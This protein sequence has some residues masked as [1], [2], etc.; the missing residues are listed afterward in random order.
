MKT[1]T[2]YTETDR[3]FYPTPKE[4]AK[5]MLSGIKWECIKNILEPSAGKG[6]LIEAIEE[7]VVDYFQN[8][9]V[10]WGYSNNDIKKEFSIDCIEIDPYLRAI[11]KGTIEKNYEN[12]KVVYDDFL[13]FITYKKYD[14]IVMNPP[15]R[16][17]YKHL[18]KALEM[19]KNGGSVICLLN[20]ETL[21]NPNNALQKELKAI[22]DKYD[23]DIEYIENGFSAAERKTDVEIA[24]IKVFI[25]EVERESDIY[26]GMKKAVN[27]EVMPNEDI[28]DLD[29]T[30][31]IKMIVTHY[32]IET[33]A[34]IKLINEYN[35][36]SPYIK[37]SFEKACYNYPMLELRMCDKSS[38]SINDYVE[39]VRL[40]YWREL[41]SNKKIMSK[42]TSALQEKYQEEVETLADYDFNEFNINNLIIE[43]NASLN[44]G[45]ADE[46]E[47]MYDRLT[48]GYTY[49]PECKNNRHYYNGWKTN[50]AHK[51]GKKVI[52]PTYG[53]YSSW[54]SKLN[55]RAAYEVLSDI[56]RILN[57]LDGNMT[58]DVD[59]QSTIEKAFN[60]SITKNIECKFFKAT[61]YKKGTVHIVFTNPDLIDKYN[62]YIGGRRNWLPPH[63]GSKK[64]TDMSEEEKSVI[65]SFQGKEAYNKI[66]ANKGFYLSGADVA[67]LTD[68]FG[69]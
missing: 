52:L 31:F 69:H 21:K 42:L 68:S 4:I 50:I 19:Q 10:T 12:V 67:M 15:F 28:T 18:L 30:D 17:G 47:V 45:I 20:A 27:I 9:W 5:K 8:K 51:I 58:A 26:N 34:G 33:G 55:I 25:E 13:Q 23:A 43:M 36:L 48:E 39:K 54:S 35:A 64:Y 11:I 63:Y 65:D 38:F 6:N 22:L 14:L 57:F 49:Y 44:K 40:K 56:E 29:V 60:D 41:L 37:K 66:L 3:Q 2:N 24:I 16:D 46:I 59:L 61:F 1:I 7:E 32:R 62:I 53:V